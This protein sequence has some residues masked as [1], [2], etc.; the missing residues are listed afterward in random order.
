MSNHQ[1]LLTSYSCEQGEEIPHSL[2]LYWVGSFNLL[3]ILSANGEIKIRE[4]DLGGGQVW[5]WKEI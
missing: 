3:F 1:G 4:L 5:H 2:S